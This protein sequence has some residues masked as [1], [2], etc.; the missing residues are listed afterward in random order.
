VEKKI[1]CFL[2]IIRL[3]FRNIVFNS[4]FI[5][6]VKGKIKGFSRVINSLLTTVEN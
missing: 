1:S 5:D 6:Y 3:F 2:L 4:L